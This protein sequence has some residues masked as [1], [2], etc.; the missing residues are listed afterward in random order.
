MN[1]GASIMRSGQLLFGVLTA[2]AAGT[3]STPHSSGIGEMV[4]PFGPMTASN[5][6]FPVARVAAEDLGASAAS[7]GAAF[8]FKAASPV[9]IYQPKSPQ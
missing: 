2:F 6:A 7:M 1:D 8:S 9:D 5:Y 4:V 3:M